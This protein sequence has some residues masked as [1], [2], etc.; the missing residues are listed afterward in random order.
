MKKLIA[1]LLLAT[2]SIN[3]QDI[4]KVK[5]KKEKFGTFGLRNFK[6]APKRLFINSFN[7]GVEIFRENYAFKR[8]GNFLK[9]G[10]AEA[11]A[12]VGITGLIKEDFQREID[13][14]YQ[15][16][17]QDFKDKGIEIITAEEVK[18]LKFFEGYESAKGPYIINSSTPG[19]LTGCP[20]GHTQFYQAKK[21]GKV[22]KSFMGEGF[23]NPKL[24]DELEDALVLDV[25]LYLMFA[26]AKSKKGI[27][28]AKSEILINPRLADS[29]MIVNKKKKTKLGIFGSVGFKGAAKTYQLATNYTIGSGKKGLYFEAQYQSVLD[30]SIEIN[31]ILK[32]Q[33]FKAKAYQDVQIGERNSFLDELKDVSVK[34]AIWLNVDSKKYVEGMYNACHAFLSENNKVLFDKMEL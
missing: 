23:K 21:S 9:T 18:G 25:N 31:G 6:K 33:T 26:S 4:G 12:A 28:S 1:I 2:L 17:I 20:T 5:I 19:I 32:K 22:K 8:K 15:D 7:V 34:N 3:A 16:F 11:N 30:E 27:V 24:S 13:R 10:N 29:E 14:V